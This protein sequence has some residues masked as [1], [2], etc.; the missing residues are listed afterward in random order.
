MA[1]P[2]KIKYLTK[3]VSFG[4]KP[5]TL[6][7]LDG[8]TWSS[9]KDELVEIVERHESEKLSFGEIRG[10]MASNKP[11]APKKVPAEKY[12][13]RPGLQKAEQRR[14]AEYAARGLETPKV[15]KEVLAQEELDNEALSASNAKKSKSAPAAKKPARAAAP[16]VVQKTKIAAKAAPQKSKLPEKAA[17]KPAAKKAKVVKAAAAPK[18]R[19]TSKPA[20]KTSVKAAKGKKKAA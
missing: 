6:F 16:A 5:L 11:I 12:K 13:F 1:D 3:T 2:K 15:N 9:R 14:S 7:S 18:K 8:L 20:G 17:P 19:A 4:G 10:Q